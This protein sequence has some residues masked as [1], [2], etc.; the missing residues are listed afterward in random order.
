MAERQEELRKMFRDE[1]FDDHESLG[2]SGGKNVR[3][4]K[5]PENVGHKKLFELSENH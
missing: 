3:H 2:A 4:S 5:S 1:L